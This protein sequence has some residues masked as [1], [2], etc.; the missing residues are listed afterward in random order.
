MTIII[1]WWLE[2]NNDETIVTGKYW[3]QDCQQMSLDTEFLEMPN[4]SDAKIDFSITLIKRRHFSSLSN[5]WL[6]TKHKL[7][8]QAR[9]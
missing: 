6:A 5:D 9:G 7:Q 2:T 3:T 1:T 4:K 8:W